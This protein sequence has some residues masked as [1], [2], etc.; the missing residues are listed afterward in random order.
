M[1]KKDI[2][3]GSLKYYAS[4]DNPEQYKIF[5]REKVDMYIAESLSGS[6]ND[7]ARALHAEYG[8]EFV[9]S[10]IVNKTWYQFKKHRWHS[11]KSTRPRRVLSSYL[12]TMF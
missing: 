11:R 7:I 6:H 10:S 12:S 3:I 1:V 8:D 5:K 9:C 2:T 4:I